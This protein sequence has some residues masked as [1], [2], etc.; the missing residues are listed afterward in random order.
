[1]SPT[2]FEP[3]PETKPVPL[4]ERTGC[5]WPIETGHRVYFCNAPINPKSRNNWCD[6]HYKLGNSTTYKGYK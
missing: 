5:C 4:E 3:L 6:T 1:M 2:A